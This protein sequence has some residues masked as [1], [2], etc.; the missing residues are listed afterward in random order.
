MEHIAKAPNG[1]WGY[2]DTVRYEGQKVFI[3]EHN[4]HG[5]DIG[6]YIAQVDNKYYKIGLD[7]FDRFE[8]EQGYY[9]QITSL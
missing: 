7:G 4:E 1:F 9:P 6:F 5:E 2:I 3:Y 8:F